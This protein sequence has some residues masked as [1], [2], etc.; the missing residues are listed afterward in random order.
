[1]ILSESEKNRIRTLHREASVIK[2]PLNEWAA[3]SAAFSSAK[4][5]L[6]DYLSG[7]EGM[8]P[9]VLQKKV[10][11]VIKKLSPAEQEKVKQ[12]NVESLVDTMMKWVKGESGLLP[13]DQSKAKAALKKL[14]MSGVGKTL[15]DVKKGKEGMKESRFISEAGPFQD[16]VLTPE[17]GKAVAEKSKSEGLP[18]CGELLK[19]QAMDKQKE[20]MDSYKDMQS[21]GGVKKPIPTG[22]ISR[23]TVD[24][25]LQALAG[26]LPPKASGV[27]ALKDGKP[28]CRVS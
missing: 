22:G 13:G 19:K 2:Q 11:S 15:A 7:K 27:I 12:G 6:S 5:T 3:V 28:F 18:K 24:V 20:K 1:M 23:V 16:E 25:T 9:D 17:K 26:P 10:E 14:V 8:V 4:D 21:G